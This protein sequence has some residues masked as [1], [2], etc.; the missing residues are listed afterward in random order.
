MNNNYFQI[1]FLVPPDRPDLQHFSRVDEIYLQRRIDS[2]EEYLIKSPTC[3][4]DV[5]KE[6]LLA[7]GAFTLESSIYQLL[8]GW[9]NTQGRSTPD[10]D[11]VAPY[12]RS[13]TTSLR[14][15]PPRF[16]YKGCVDFEYLM[17]QLQNYN[18]LLMILKIILQLE[19]LLIFIQSQ[20]GVM[21]QHSLMDSCQ[22]QDHH[23]VYSFNV[24]K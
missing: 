16:H 14:G 7:I 5:D 9:G 4:M 15:L 1:N 2:V 24:M 12:F 23:Q 6:H 11:H 3:P 19:N 20:A 13:L 17:H 18:L 22:D 21:T 10:M 8:N